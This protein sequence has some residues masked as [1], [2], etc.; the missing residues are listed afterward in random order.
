MNATKLILGAA[1]AL[2]LTA[3]AVTKTYLHDDIPEPVLA[4][5]PADPGSATLISTASP[6]L[7]FAGVTLDAFTNDVTFLAYRK[8]GEYS[9]DN[10]GYTI[11]RNVTC[12]DVD[13][14]GKADKIVMQFSDMDNNG[15]R[16]A[17]LQLT[18]G[19]G[20][21]YVQQIHALFGASSAYFSAFTVAADGTITYINHGDQHGAW[22]SYCVRGFVA[23]PRCLAATGVTDGAPQSAIPIDFF[24]PTNTVPVTPALQLAFPNSTLDDLADCSFVTYRGRGVID[25][26]ALDPQ[27]AGYY[28]GKFKTSV[29]TDNDG[30]S[31]KI[32]FQFDGPFAADNRISVYELTNG[33]GGVYVRKAVSMYSNNS[34]MF[35]KKAFDVASDGT[36]SVT[37]GWN[38]DNNN[39]YQYPARGLVAIAP[40]SGTPRSLLAINGAAPQDAPPII[41]DYPQ[42]AFP[43]ATLDD[44]AECSFVTYRGRGSIAPCSLDPQHAAYYFASAV[45]SVDTD[46]DGHLDKIVMQFEGLSGGDNRIAVYELINGE[47]GVYVRKTKNL[48]ITDASKFHTQHFNVAADG[49][50]SY[51]GGWDNRFDYA[52]RGLVAIPNAG[53]ENAPVRLWTKKGGVLTLNDLAGAKFTAQLCGGS[54]NSGSIANLMGAVV[55]DGLNTHE[56]T[57]A[58]GNIT[59]IVTEFQYNDGGTAKSV[60]VKLSN[61]ADGVYG[62]SLSACDGHTLGYVTSGMSKWPLARPHLSAG[63]GVC[64]LKAIADTAKIY[65]QGPTRTFGVMDMAAPTSSTKFPTS[66]VAG[67]SGLTLE[68]LSGCVFLSYMQ[69]GSIAGRYLLGKHPTLYPTSGDAEKLA[70]QFTA[71]DGSW[72]KSAY[73]QFAYNANGAVT[74]QKV[75]NTWTS[76]GNVNANTKTFNDNFF[77]V[78][79]SDGSSYDNVGSNHNNT[80]YDL[81][82]LQVFPGFVQTSP[83]LLFKGATLN[84]IENATFTARAAGGW[85]PVIVNRVDGYNRHVVKDGS[86]DV[87]SIVVEFQYLDGSTVK[88]VVVRFENGE[89]GVYGTAI[90]KCWTNTSLGYQFVNYDGEG[91]V[92]GYNGSNDDGAAVNPIDD[93]YGVYDVQATVESDANEWTLDADR[94]WSSFTGG[95][96]F[97]D[98]A[99]TV[100]VKVTENGATLT[101]DENVTVGKI[102]FVNAAGVDVTTNALVVASGVNTSILAIEAA[103]GVHLT[104]PTSLGALSATAGIGATVAYS[105]DGTVSGVLSG[106]G[107]VAVSSGRVTFTGANDFTGGFVVRSGAVAVAG[108]SVAQGAAT[109]PF[110]AIDTGSPR[111]V[112]VEAGGMVDVNGQNGLGYRFALAGSGVATGDYAAPGPIVNFGDPLTIGIC[113]GNSSYWT[114]GHAR[115]Y[116]LDGDV[117]LGTAGEDV[118]IVSES[119][120]ENA[121]FGCSLELGGYTLTKAGEGTLWMWSSGLNVTGNGTLTVAEGVVDIRKGAYNGATSTVAVG[122]DGTLRIGAALNAASVVNN[123]RIEV[124]TYWDRARK[125]TTIS[126]AYSGTGTL[127]VLSDGILTLNNNLSVY[128]FVNNGGISGA[129]MLTVTGTLTPGN[130]I[131]HLTLAGGATIK[132]TGLNNAQAVTGV[133][134]AAG[135]VNVDGSAISDDDLKAAGM[136]PVL[137]ASSLPA[138]IKQ[139]LVAVGARNRRFRV[140]TDNGVST[141]YMARNKGFVIFVK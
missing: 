7:A 28:Y 13:G 65:R 40:Q 135:T 75:H 138:D 108:A 139:R 113:N 50:V 112:T 95:E 16:C 64:G 55:A 141:V 128:D 17:V 19:D 106:A 67:F 90:R 86:G 12:R 66:E 1:V 140:V 51:N 115:G 39:T 41:N 104:V 101:I 21:V 3:G 87:T 31:D 94:N 92:S 137:S 57:D 25:N 72:K 74:I 69:S 22:Q 33:D 120:Y 14:D 80:Q 133:F 61:G 125:T 132:L 73:I 136:V 102:V 9:F 11:A 89:G 29:D 79:P 117:T 96:A 47:G 49:T 91:N 2:T 123:G 99:A 6:Q 122:A 98:D 121:K 78:G 46:S 53:Y 60:A 116:A 52:A 111:S 58:S 81:W 126:G 59:N 129:G 134:A 18:N 131:P 48:Y 97:D 107:A 105:G 54:V 70:V 68:D 45:K 63:I 27:H 76:S 15:E 127:A 88:V 103:T 43:G 24:A 32:V 118:G 85:L 4:I 110:G 10:A 84:D 119:Q 56:F 34:S 37:S 38:W 83:T 30:H 130:A 82:G 100:R 93:G 5:D 62:Q 109:G 36:V 42:F 20:G 77:T 35:G 44:L 8:G 114:T 26:G 23:V 71:E 124:T